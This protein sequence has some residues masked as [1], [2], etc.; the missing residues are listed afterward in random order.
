MVN[1]L[2]TVIDVIDDLLGEFFEFFD[3]LLRFWSLR[4]GPVLEYEVGGWCVS[5][6]E[7]RH[8]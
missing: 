4:L 1:E 5:N 3:F 8:N 7:R 2:S 6:F